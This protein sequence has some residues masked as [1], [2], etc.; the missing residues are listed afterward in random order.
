MSRPPAWLVVPPPEA[1]A[2]PLSELVKASSS[3]VACAA[4]RAIEAAAPPV[5]FPRSCAAAKRPSRNRH[6]PGVDGPTFR[7]GAGDGYVAL[8]AV[9]LGTATT[10]DSCPCGRIVGISRLDEGLALSCRLREMR[11]PPSTR[12]GRAGAR[13][14]D[15]G[16]ANPSELL[17]DLDADLALA[18]DGLAFAGGAGFVP[19]LTPGFLPTRL[20]ATFILSAMPC[21]PPNL[22]PAS[23]S[24]AQRTVMVPEPSSVSVPVRVRADLVS[25]SLRASCPAARVANRRVDGAGCS[26]HLVSSPFT[27]SMTPCAARPALPKNRIKPA[28]LDAAVSREPE[29]YPVF[30]M[31]PLSPI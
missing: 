15:D 18:D 6:G 21:L 11:P 4:D 25:V 28:V 23:A 30:S 9:C 29:T 24:H 3:A 7:A 2:R 20:S 8:V 16:H 14:N 27:S 12:M 13:W 19:L 10:R 31:P 26:N 22:M 17:H 1:G 5:L